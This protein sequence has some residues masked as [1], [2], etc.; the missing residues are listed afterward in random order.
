MTGEASQVSTPAPRVEPA[1]QEKSPLRVGLIGLGTVGCGVVRLLRRNGEQ[2]HRHGGRPVKLVCVSARD[3]GKKRSVKLDGL[4][5]IPEAQQL[6]RRPDLDVV[7]EL[8]GGL[9]TAGKVVRTALRAG[10]HVV[11][12][13]KALLAA[14]GEELFA[15]ARRHNVRLAFEAAVCGGMPLIKVLREGLA[16]NRI[17]AIT[18]IV[19]G[20]CNYILSAMEEHDADF[21]AV[22]ETAR[23]KGY[24]EADPTADLQGLDAA[25]KLAVLAAI[26]FGLPL[27]G[28]SVYRE[29]ISEIEAVDLRY[30]RELGYRLRHLAIARRRPQGIELRTHPTLLPE[31]HPLARVRGVM[32]AVLLQGDAVGSILLSGAGAGGAP[33][34][35]A[36]L[37]DLADL[38]AVAAGISAGIPRDTPPS[39]AETPVGATGITPPILPVTSTSTACYLRMQAEDRPGVLAEISGVLSKEGISV[40]AV[41]Q[42]EPPPGARYATIL[43]ITRQLLEAHI[44]SAR[45][46]LEKLPM[47]HGPVTR[48]RLLPPD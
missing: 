13:N 34:A 16:G 2:L 41:S 42:K 6:A 24:T 33:T 40:E 38:A 15:L 23:S 48:I 30:A 21:S 44:E 43:F 27:R 39:V 3:P 4:E 35:S 10:K 31:N 9:E 7:V 8:I 26:A 45:T 28:L 47:L 5:F 1:L 25:Q 20:T 11:T 46:R 22:L 29:G 12:A 36:V 17:E 18:G 19:N 32:N 14:H 37:A